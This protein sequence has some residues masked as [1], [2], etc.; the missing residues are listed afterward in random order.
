MVANLEIVT[1]KIVVVK[2]KVSQELSPSGYWK[3]AC[4]V[5]VFS[6]PLRNLSGYIAHIVS[7]TQTTWKMVH[8]EFLINNRRIN[9]PRLKM[10]A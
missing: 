4:R 3:Y 1:T 9:F 8:N 10:L 6:S 2:Q 5:Y 7:F